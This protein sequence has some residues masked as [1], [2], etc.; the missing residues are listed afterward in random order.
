[1]TFDEFL[2][3]PPC[4]TGKHSTVDDTPQ[5]EP[6]TKPDENVPPPKPI[7]EDNTP[8]LPKAQAPAAAQPS[9]QTETKPEEFDSDDPDATIP[10]NTTCRRRGCN[11]TSEQKESPCVYHPGIAVF[12]EGS[13]GWSCCKRRVLEFDEF[14]KIEG[15]ATRERHSFLPKKKANGVNGEELE[16]VKVVRHDFY[17]TADKVTASLY[18]KKI[19]KTKSS[20]QFAE[21][22]QVVRLDLKTSDGKQYK[23]DVPLFAQIVPEKSSFRILGTKLELTLSK[24]DGQGWP[25]LRTD[26]ERLTGEI[27]QTGRAGRA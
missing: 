26:T 7:S 16:E 5:P 2:T 25:I 22:G 24:G 18:L 8:R 11:V 4:T 21:G 3:I 9:A 27:I 20:V 15:C 1:L 12:H 14:M 23:A 19:D 10:A 6:T 17:Q 13:K